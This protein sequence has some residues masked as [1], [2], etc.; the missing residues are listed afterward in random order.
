[1][2]K[3]NKTTP[4]GKRPDQAQV[5]LERIKT[6]VR[7]GGNPR[8]HLGFNELGE[9]IE[10]VLGPIAGIEQFSLF[11]S[12][13]VGEP[14]SLVA[15]GGVPKSDF[16]NVKISHGDGIAG[17]AAVTGVPF[18]ATR[19]D[20]Q[21][22]DGGQRS[23]GGHP[24]AACLPIKISTGTAG[25]LVVHKMRTQTIRASHREMLTILAEQLGP[26]VETILMREEMARYAKNVDAANSDIART[27]RDLERQIDH[28]HTLSLFAV[29][30]HSSLELENVFEQVRGLSMN[31]IGIDR[32]HIVMVFEGEW[33]TYHGAADPAADRSELAASLGK[34][35][36]IVERVMVS[37]L[38]LFPDSTDDDDFVACLPLKIKDE[39]VG[40]FLV[41]S[42]ID[43]NTTFGDNK[44]ELLNMLT[45]QA[46]L[47]ITAGYL[48]T[49]VEHMAITDGLT[50]LYD[51]RHIEHLVRR[52]ISRAKRYGEPVAI[53]MADIDNFKRIN[54]TFG[55]PFGDTVLKSIGAAFRAACREGDLVGRY[56]GEEFLFILSRTDREGAAAFAERIRLAAESLKFSAR[57][58][59]LTVT[60]SVGAAVRDAHE[61]WE[62]L[63]RSADDALY[64]A[65]RQGKNRVV[66]ANDITELEH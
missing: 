40:V 52:E 37:G 36:Q 22:E 12:R 24:I 20:R 43:G 34:L 45:E 3:K 42:L 47:A 17:A 13:F 64:T 18:F 8:L 19:S 14:F 54:D 51:R 65:K 15:S 25:V 57:G 32:F 30:L 39:T 1:M 46:A 9:A 55:H 58:K 23:I 61:T 28:L 35:S 16:A 49:R 33:I 63:L 53:A 48:Y 10:S 50:G 62:D 59:P 4:R 2:D 41:R 27:T 7:A 66:L 60:V 29:R 6:L 26:I 56:G 44:M 11:I 38:P 5:Q 31:F 21:S